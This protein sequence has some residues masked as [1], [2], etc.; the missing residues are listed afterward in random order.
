MRETDHS[1]S[2][3]TEVKIAFNYTSTPP[4]RIHGMMINLAREMSSWHD[5]YLSTGKI[6]LTCGVPCFKW[7]DEIVTS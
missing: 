5:T 2:S 7:T 1:L 6:Y 3:N 4:T